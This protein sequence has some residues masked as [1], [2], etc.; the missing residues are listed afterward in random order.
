MSTDP[1]VIHGAELPNLEIDLLTPSPSFWYDNSVGYIGTFLQVLGCNIV[2]LYKPYPPKMGSLAII[3]RSVYY[4]PQGDMLPAMFI[5]DAEKFLNSDYFPHWMIGVNLLYMFNIMDGTIEALRM[6]F[7]ISNG[8]FKNMHPPRMYPSSGFQEGWVHPYSIDICRRERC[9]R[10]FA[11]GGPVMRRT[12][13]TKDGVTRKSYV[14]DC[15]CMKHTE[16]LTAIHPFW[17]RTIKHGIGDIV[18]ASLSN[19]EIVAEIS[20]GVAER[21]KFDEFRNLF[22]ILVGLSD[23]IDVFSKRVP[24]IPFLQTMLYGRSGPITDSKQMKV[25]ISA[26]S[27]FIHTPGYGVMKFFNL[28]ITHDSRLEFSFLREQILKRVESHTLVVVHC[29]KM[30]PVDIELDYK[31]VMADKLTTPPWNFLIDSQEDGDD[32]DDDTITTHPTIIFPADALGCKRWPLACCVLAN[33]LTAHDLMTV[34]ER[35]DKVILF[36]DERFPSIVTRIL[37]HYPEIKRYSTHPNSVVGKFCEKDDR[38]VENLPC[39]ILAR[40]PCLNSVEFEIAN[41]NC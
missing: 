31:A 33:M 27:H 23:D 38:F 13:K 21:T 34:F 4:V 26:V 40:F 10:C 36:H 28:T 17:L 22:Y 8:T 2:Q 32:D 12:R 3:G 1:L 24:E 39:S 37:R 29:E 6:Q 20:A 14:D 9:K 5:V 15:V 7:P 41:S 11:T 18:L 19:A 35:C 25:V 30:T 16:L